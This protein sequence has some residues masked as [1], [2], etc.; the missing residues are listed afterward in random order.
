VARVVWTRQARRDLRN[1]R[2]FIATD[3][4][5]LADIVVGRLIAAVGRLQDFPLSGRVVPEV[6]REDVREVISSNFRIVYRLRETRVEVA[7]VF[8]STW[9]VRLPE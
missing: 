8:H 9:S 5:L 3:A 1:I 7:T 2:D 6:G 4:P